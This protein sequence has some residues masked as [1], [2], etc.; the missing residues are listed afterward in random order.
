MDAAS[1]AGSQNPF[2]EVQFDPGRDFFRPAAQLR[3]TEMP[4]PQQAARL[5]PAPR[6]SFLRRHCLL[7]SVLTLLLLL[8][9]AGYLMY[10]PRVRMALSKGPYHAEIAKVQDVERRVDLHEL[11]YLWRVCRRPAVRDVLEATLKSAVAGAGVPTTASPAPLAA[12]APATDG[13]A[14]DGSADPFFTAA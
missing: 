11:H 2:G 10:Y 6:K 3:P 1:F 9:V 14:A 7:L 5:P 4:M 12:A 8:L 13:G